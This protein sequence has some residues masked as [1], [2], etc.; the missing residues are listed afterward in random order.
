MITAAG[1]IAIATIAMVAVVVPPS[2]RPTTTIAAG[3]GQ[4]AGLA[5]ITAAGRIAITTIVTV[6]AIAAV[7]E[8]GA[9]K[10]KA[11]GLVVP[12]STRLATTI[13]VRGGQCAGLAMITAGGRR[14]TIPR[15]LSTAR[16]A[17]DNR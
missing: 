11:V 15:E 7:G 4:R 16:A 5:M 17:R 12:P 6:A 1:R 9:R 8:H 10:K 14:F 2:A 3:G 13:A